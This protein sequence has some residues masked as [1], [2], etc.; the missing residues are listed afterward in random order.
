MSPQEK[1]Q[2][3]QGAIVVAT[4]S[5]LVDAGVLMHRVREDSNLFRGAVESMG[6]PN[7][8][9]RGIQNELHAM[10]MA[11]ASVPVMAVQMDAI[12]R[13]MSVMSHGVGSTMGRMGSWMPW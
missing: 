13:N 3:L 7:E 4:G 10:N 12:N 5:V 9:L 6:G 2:I 8:L 11:L 1:A